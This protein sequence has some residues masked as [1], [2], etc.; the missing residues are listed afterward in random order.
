[1]TL[2][3]Q[4]IAISFVALFLRLL[5]DLRGCTSLRSEG[6]NA[7]AVLAER[8]PMAKRESLLGGVAV[9]RNAY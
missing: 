2:G 8:V 6:V 5:I 9:V 7:R 1:M 3:W 4:V